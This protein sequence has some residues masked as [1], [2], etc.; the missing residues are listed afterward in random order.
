MI[1]LADLLGLAWLKALQIGVPDALLQDGQAPPLVD[2]PLPYSCQ[3]P[4][5]SAGQTHLVVQASEH[6]AC[7]TMLECSD[8]DR[9]ST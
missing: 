6:W 4:W 3:L 8:V 9:E 5:S 2:L 7:K 1:W